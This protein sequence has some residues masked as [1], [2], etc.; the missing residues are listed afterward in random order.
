M[1]I[2]YLVKWQKNRS[3]EKIVKL[4]VL[5]SNQSYVMIYPELKINRNE[6]LTFLRNKGIINKK[7]KPSSLVKIKE[8]SDIQI[9]GYFKTLAYELLFYYSCT[10]DFS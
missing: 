5:S 10:N 7:K 1:L 6:V 3:K 4:Q 9:L 8:I 2:D